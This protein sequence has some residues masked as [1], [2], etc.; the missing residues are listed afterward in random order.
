MASS[1]RR[2]LLK[3]LL[4]SAIESPRRKAVRIFTK[5]ID[6][7][8]NGDLS[9][10]E[11]R[12]YL[13]T[14]SDELGLKKLDDAVAAQI[15]VAL[16]ADA[17]GVISLS[18]WTAVFARAATAKQHADASELEAAWLSSVERA[19]Q[20]AAVEAEATALLAA[21]EIPKKNSGHMARK[22]AQ[23]ALSAAHQAADKAIAE[24]ELADK[25]VQQAER[26]AEAAG[27]AAASKLAAVKKALEKEAK[28]KT[29]ARAAA[30]AAAARLAADE[31]AMAATVAENAA[32]PGK[33]MLQGE[34]KI[35]VESAKPGISRN[36]TRGGAFYSSQISSTQRER[37]KQ[38]FV[39]MVTDATASRDLEAASP[40]KPAA[41]GARLGN[42]RILAATASSKSKVSP[43]P[44]DVSSSPYLAQK[45]K[46]KKKKRG[47]R[48]KV[49]I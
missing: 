1:G 19:K 41:D 8:Q 44:A 47:K 18:E 40:V 20:R 10:A 2:P 22:R 45:K 43:T 33:G 39:S 14:S 49:K 7:D 38:I 13:E 25:E 27:E 30:A 28:A 16:D 3:S 42:S 5:N 17:N 21:T 35:G 4:A 34:A 11:L 23:E 6:V 29:A 31:A 15:F 46:K 26:K 24:R 12:R 37:K 9:F 36:P 48:K 32:L